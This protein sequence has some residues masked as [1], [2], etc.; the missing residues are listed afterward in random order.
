MPQYRP[1]ES[2]RARQLE[3]TA[4]LRLAAA[5]R[6]NRNADDYLLALVLFA[7]SLFFAGISTKLQSSRQREVLLG[8]G[9]LIFLTAVIWVATIPVN[10]S[11]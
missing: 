4:D 3:S 9:C 10:F 7:S 6:S 1:A 11:F 2:E 8:L 5:G